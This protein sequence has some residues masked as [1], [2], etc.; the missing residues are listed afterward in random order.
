MIASKEEEEEEEVPAVGCS[1]SFTVFVHVR[2][3]VCLLS[4]VYLRRCPR[5][6]RTG[7]DQ[8]TN[9]AFRLKWSPTATS[10][11]RHTKS[12]GPLRTAQQQRT[13][14]PSS[15]AFREACIT[16]QTFPSRHRYFDRRM[17]I[18]RHVLFDSQRQLTFFGIGEGGGATTE[19]PRSLLN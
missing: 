5:C 18:V 19:E 4:C 15:F 3:C 6:R 7:E 8:T 9:G 10:S 1:D 12:S 16:T 2:T 13:R 11:A 17:P 14:Q